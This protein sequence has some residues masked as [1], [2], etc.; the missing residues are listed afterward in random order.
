MM[1]DGNLNAKV[2]PEWKHCEEEI[3]HNWSKVGGEVPGGLLEVVG[4]IGK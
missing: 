3:V 1:G 2:E 4:E